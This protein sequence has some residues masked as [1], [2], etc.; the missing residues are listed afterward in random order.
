MDEDHEFPD[1]HF[2]ECLK[3]IEI[4]PHVIWTI[5]E[6]A[7]RDLHRSLPSQFAG[8]LHPRGFLMYQNL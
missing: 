7:Q 4:E 6:Y 8:Q 5:V 2:A 3:V 1:N